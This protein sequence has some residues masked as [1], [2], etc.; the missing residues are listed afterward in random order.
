MLDALK[1]AGAIA[2]LMK[3]ADGLK[4]AGERI[5]ARLGELRA[6]GQS[7]SG[8]VRVT[9]DGKMTVLDVAI[10]PSMAAC[11]FGSPGGAD[12][13]AAGRLIADAINDAI[14]Q[15]Q[16]MAQREIAREAQALGLPDIPGLGSL[17]G[18]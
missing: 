14:R 18:P 7:G 3:N 13:A 10:D 11:A 2:G 12:A 6:I 8:A 9:V 17:L 15:A 5:K 1:A 16:A 4:A